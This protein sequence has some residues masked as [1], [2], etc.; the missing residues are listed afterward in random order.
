MP[1]GLG[2]TEEIDGHGPRVADVDG[3]HTHKIDIEVQGLVQVADAQAQVVQLEAY[4]GSIGWEGRIGV[5]AT[6][7]GG[8]MGETRHCG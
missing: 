3:A 2:V 4:R 1:V 5:E 7:E 8:A 6:V